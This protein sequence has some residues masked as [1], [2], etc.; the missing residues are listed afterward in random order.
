MSFMTTKAPERDASLSAAYVS[1]A[2]SG[3]LLLLAAGA[4]FGGRTSAGV[5]L[6][7]VLALSNLWVVERLVRLTLENAGGR[8]AAI[9]LVKAAVLFGL[10]ALLVK[11]GAVDVLA[12]VAGFGALPLGVVVAGMLPLARASGES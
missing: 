9:A 6:G 8:W 11:T 3:A 1:V 7:V 2:A 5:G 12:L 4:S 10:V